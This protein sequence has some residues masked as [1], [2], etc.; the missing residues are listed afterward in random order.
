MSEIRAARERLRK[1]WHDHKVNTYMDIPE[2][3]TTDANL[4][5]CHDLAAHPPDDNERIT[6]EW[7]DTLSERQESDGGLVWVLGQC[8]T[9]GSVTI[10][11]VTYENGTFTAFYVSG[12][13]V[14]MIHTRGD[15]RLLCRALGIPLESEVSK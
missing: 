9:G 13:K 12:T 8:D 1:L 6:E 2:S 10:F 11:R 3:S 7:L 15:V 4:L 5:A 14:R